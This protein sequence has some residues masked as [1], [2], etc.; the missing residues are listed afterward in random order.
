MFKI[1]VFVIEIIL[2]YVT[3]YISLGIVNDSR[4][5]NKEHNM[6]LKFKLTKD[7]TLCIERDLEDVSSEMEFFIKRSNGSQFR[8]YWEFDE[9]ETMYGLLR[10]MSESIHKGNRYG[11]FAYQKVFIDKVNAYFHAP[12]ELPKS[13]WRMTLQIRR[14]TS[15]THLHL[16]NT[17]LIDVIGYKEF[18]Q[19]KDAIE[20]G[21]LC[22]QY[23]T[24]PNYEVDQIEKNAKI[25]LIACLNNLVYHLLKQ[26]KREP[27]EVLSYQLGVGKRRGFRSPYDRVY[28]RGTNRRHQ[29]RYTK[30]D[31]D[32]DFYNFSKTSGKPL[33]FWAVSQAVVKNIY[34]YKHLF[35]I[36][37]RFFG[38][39][40]FDSDLTMEAI[41]SAYALEYEEFKEFEH[42]Y[43][44]FPS[45]YIRTFFLVE[46][47]YKSQNLLKN[48]K[49]PIV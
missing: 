5:T 35:D 29:D 46:K 4:Y 16:I 44:E 43:M 6:L 2:A 28:K 18:N 11:L 17:L 45:N 8:L 3:T 27:M 34:L 12:P 38:L 22:S 33:E 47:I 25:I 7:Y 13:E 14:F 41:K 49:L 30:D 36:V 42:P 32:L 9:M 24:I 1:L 23:A 20:C 19:F 40:L 48:A 39:E 37:F 15:N 31:L 21:V 10:F 26:I